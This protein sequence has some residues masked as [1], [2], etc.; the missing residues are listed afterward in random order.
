MRRLLVFFKFYTEK[1]EKKNL[2]ACSGRLPHSLGHI[3]PGRLGTASTLAAAAPPPPSPLPPPLLPHP[4]PFLPPP[5]SFF[6]TVSH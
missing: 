4:L 6:E 3:G 2:L 1:E 5:T